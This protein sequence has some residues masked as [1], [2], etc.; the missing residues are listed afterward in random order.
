MHRGRL[1][2][3]VATAILATACSLS[4]Q[5]GATTTTLRGEGF[6]LADLVG[7]WENRELVMQVGDDGQYVV[8]EAANE[9]PSDP[10]MSGFVARDGEELNFVTDIYGECA[11][12]TGVYEVLMS[13]GQ[14]ILILVDDPC[15]FRSDRFV[16]PWESSG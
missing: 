9:E 14:L 12:E 13:E 11:G 15:E 16:D 7:E 4:V 6:T 3:L 5:V 10:L 2:M 8:H 1:L